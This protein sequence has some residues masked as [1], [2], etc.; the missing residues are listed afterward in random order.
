MTPVYDI[1]AEGRHITT[2]LRG[3]L[4]SLR[5]TDQAGFESDSVEIQLAKSVFSPVPRVGDT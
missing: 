4:L 2:V 3:R 1:R 5:V